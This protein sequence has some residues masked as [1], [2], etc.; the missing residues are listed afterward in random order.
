MEDSER[1]RPVGWH[2]VATRPAVPGWP[3][4]VVVVALALANIVGNLW[5]P[6]WAYVPVNLVVALSLVFVARRTGITAAELGL[7]RSQ[8]R[9]GLRVGLLVGGLVLLAVGV[10]AAV[11]WAR[12]AFDDDR[13]GGELA[14][15][16]Y[17]TTVR[18]PLGTALYEE[19]LFRGVLLALLLRRFGTVTAVTWS[20]LL[21]GLWHV[22]PSLG[23][24]EGNT[25]VAATGSGTSGLVVVVVG[26]VVAT[27]LAG[28]AFCWLRLRAD[29]LVAPVLV[30]V[31][32]NSG[33]YAAAYVVTT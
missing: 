30:H 23:V 24:A 6:T 19:V 15:L 3:T 2:R 31:A 25:A 29:S 26:T 16:V 33:A 5:L 21:F 17:Q 13:V 7:A 8:V 4:A 9:A 10:A 11:P 22:L 12:D 1:S 18:I 27:M 14:E 32:T 28:Y 20:S